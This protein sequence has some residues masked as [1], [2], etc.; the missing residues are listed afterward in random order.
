MAELYRET[1]TV[2][3]WNKK[4]VPIIVIAGTIEDTD[5]LLVWRSTAFIALCQTIKTSY[6][7]NSIA[8][9]CELFAPQAA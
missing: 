3:D 5:L 4:D 7:G 6:G 8:K 1:I 2:K 9:N